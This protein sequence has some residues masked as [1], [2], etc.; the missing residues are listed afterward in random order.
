MYLIVFDPETRRILSCGEVAPKYMLD[1]L[2]EGAA[3]ETTAPEHPV[4]DYLYTES[5]EYIKAEAPHD[6]DP[7]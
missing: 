6:N 7:N 5:G 3:Y 1:I 4:T 2:P